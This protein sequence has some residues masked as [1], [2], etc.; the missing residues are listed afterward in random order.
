MYMGNKLKREVGDFITEGCLVSNRR[1]TPK[2]S[3]GEGIE[4]KIKIS[5]AAI[6]FLLTSLVH[7]FHDFMLKRAPAPQTRPDPPPNVGSFGRSGVPEKC[8]L[9]K[10]QLSRDSTKRPKSYL[11]RLEWKIHINQVKEKMKIYRMNKILTYK[12]VIRV[13]L[14]ICSTGT[15]I[16]F[17]WQ[18]KLA[19]SKL[20]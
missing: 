14:H 20:R 9:H 15:Y 16:I 7:K 2:Y 5:K 19:S 8:S 13:V 10:S 11:F 17:W 12:C 1:F 6:Q 18:N 3:Q 4:L